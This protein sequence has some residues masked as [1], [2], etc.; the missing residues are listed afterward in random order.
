MFESLEIF[1]GPSVTNHLSRGSHDVCSTKLRIWHHTRGTFSGAIDAAQLSYY[2]H[3]TAQLSSTLQTKVG[4]MEPY[5]C[6]A[7]T[8]RQQLDMEHKMSLSYQT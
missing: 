8:S 7:P 1:V 5:T 6:L 2:D 4:I 3:Y